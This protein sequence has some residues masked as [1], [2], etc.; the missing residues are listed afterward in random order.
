MY[1][2]YD[3]GQIVVEE[4]F[5]TEDVHLVYGRSAFF[6]E[7]GYRCCEVGQVYRLRVMGQWGIVGTT[8]ASDIALVDDGQVD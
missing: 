4:G 6:T 7:N 3:F 1:H 8:L 5:T 2:A